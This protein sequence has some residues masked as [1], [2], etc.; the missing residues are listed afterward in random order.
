MSSSR[1]AQVSKYLF[2]LVAATI[3]LAG[4]AIPF[5]AIALAIKLDSPGPVFFRQV[6]IGRFGRPFRILKF[7]SM[8]HGRV[9]NG[10][11]TTSLDDHVTRVGRF[12]RA[13]KLDE[14]PQLINIV[15]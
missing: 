14:L 8:T 5:A 11:L 3:G 15:A 6:R 4:L 9:P 12:L 7:R 13:T 1:K 2:D 10:E